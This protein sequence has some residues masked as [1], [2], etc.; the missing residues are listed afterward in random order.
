MME[1][2]LVAAASRRRPF[3]VRLAPSLPP[4]HFSN[5]LIVA[6]SRAFSAFSSAA[7]YFNIP[8]ISP[9]CLSVTITKRHFPSLSSAHSSPKSRSIFA[10]A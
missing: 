4:R 1:P 8:S 6:S 2:A 7:P 10:A 3:S 9:H 5:S